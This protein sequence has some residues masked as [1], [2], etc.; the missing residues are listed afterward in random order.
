MRGGLFAA[1]APADFLKSSDQEIDCVV[2]LLAFR[3]FSAKTESPPMLYLSSF[4]Q[5]RT[6]N[7]FPLL[8]ELL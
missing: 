7:R 2:A 6:Q 8:L 1:A 4:A 5:F 3:A